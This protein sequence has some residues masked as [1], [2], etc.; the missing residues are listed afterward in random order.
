[1][2]GGKALSENLI[3]ALSAVGAIDET[4]FYAELFRAQKP[5]NFAVFV[6]DPRCMADPLRTAMLSQFAVI[7]QLGLRP[8]LVVNSHA[9]GNGLSVE[10]DFD[11]PV[12]TIDAH[13]FAQELGLIAQAHDPGRIIFLQ[14]SG[15]LED[16]GRRI[17]VINV[18]D[19]YAVLKPD[20]LSAGQKRFIDTALFLRN[21][22]NFDG[23]C[24]IASP[25]NLLQELFTTQGSGTLLRPAAD[26]NTFRNIEGLDQSAVTASINSA[27]GRKLRSGFP[28]ENM[29]AAFIETEN[30]GGAILLKEKPAPYLS[31]FWVTQEARGEGLARDI[32]DHMIRETPA[33]FWRSRRVNPFNAWYLESCDGMQMSGDWRVFWKGLDEADIGAAITCAAA[34]PDDFL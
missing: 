25:L 30:R 28:F 6:I 7:A 23:N 2:S 33:L 10:P 12:E 27:F 26:I 29:H 15:G 24:V 18:K 31:K 1:M 3:R 21:E 17:P 4:R 34:K 16:A 22:T 13:E 14:P 5:E 9:H 19:P 8:T 32:W 11:F 20:G